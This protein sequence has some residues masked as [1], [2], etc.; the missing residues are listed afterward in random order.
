MEEARRHKLWDIML[1]ARPLVG[2]NCRGGAMAKVLDLATQGL[3]DL[4][5]VN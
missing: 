1:T 4:P 5:C 3:K 2:K